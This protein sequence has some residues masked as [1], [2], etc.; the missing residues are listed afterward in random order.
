MYALLGAGLVCSIHY[1]LIA[2][3][4]LDNQRKYLDYLTRGSQRRHSEYIGSPTSDFPIE[5]CD[6]GTELLIPVSQFTTGRV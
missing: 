3:P 4:Y 6:V 5:R 1:R 2:K